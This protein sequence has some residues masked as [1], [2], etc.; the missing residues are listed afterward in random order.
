MPFIRYAN[1]DLATFE[2]RACSCDRGLPL[3]RSVDGREA[4]LVSLPDGR[5][6]PSLYFVHILKDYPQIRYFQVVQH[7][8]NEFVLQIVPTRP[9]VPMTFEYENKLS[10]ELGGVRVRSEVVADIPLSQSGK[11]RVFVSKIAQPT[12]TR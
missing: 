2:T 4:E 7:A 3:L 10:A 9:G 8:L 11:R 12:G 5:R 1:G 6:F